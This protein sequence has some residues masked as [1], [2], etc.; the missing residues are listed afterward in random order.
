[1]EIMEQAMTPMKFY[2][3]A[4]SALR[5]HIGE[6]SGEV[7]LSAWCHVMGPAP[8][9]QDYRI[10][11]IVESHGQKLNFGTDGVKLLVSFV[12]T[13]DA[14]LGIFRNHM[15]PQILDFMGIS[16]TPEYDPIAMGA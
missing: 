12:R 10:G 11:V 8:V 1:M 14:A 15:I 2:L 4:E 5:E 6:R 9:T 7:H 3:L 16:S 13:P